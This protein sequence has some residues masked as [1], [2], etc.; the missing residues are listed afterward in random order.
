MAR[1]LLIAGTFLAVAMM[2]AHMNGVGLDERPTLLKVGG[3]L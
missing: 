2:L 3:S 1:A